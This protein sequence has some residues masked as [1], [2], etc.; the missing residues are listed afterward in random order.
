MEWGRKNTLTWT[1][2]LLYFLS[3]TDKDTVTQVRDYIN[4]LSSLQLILLPGLTPSIFSDLVDLLNPDLVTEVMLNKRPI[5]PDIDEEVLVK[6]LSKCNYLQVL[7]LKFNSR[8]ITDRFITSLVESCTDIYVLSF[9]SSNVTAEGLE[10]L[11]QCKKIK[12]LDISTPNLTDD[13]L[14]LI[15]KSLDNLT[16]IGLSNCKKLTT[17]GVYEACIS[18]KKLKTIELTDCNVDYISLKMSL[19]SI[20]RNLEIRQ[21]KKMN[22]I[23]VCINRNIR[24]II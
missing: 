1:E 14:K 18:T 23:E 6:L 8:T 21:N 17:D 11:S 4:S 10:K 19:K 5:D 22:W 15:C 12:A 7:V 20:K 2:K 9:Q 24:Y 3:I 16:Q 13:I